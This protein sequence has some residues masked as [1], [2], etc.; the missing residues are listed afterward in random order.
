MTDGKESRIG[1]YR[2]DSAVRQVNT[3]QVVKIIAQIIGDW[4]RVENLDSGRKKK[5]TEYPRRDSARPAHLHERLI[6]IKL[7]IH[8]LTGS[9]DCR[10]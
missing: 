8:Y 6:S 9:A 2:V 10:T 7:V 4:V 1:F 3:D 5:E